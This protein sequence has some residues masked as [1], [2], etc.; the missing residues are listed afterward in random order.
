[1]SAAYSAWLRENLSAI[2]LAVVGVAAAVVG[3]AAAG[4]VFWYAGT[5]FAGWL[6]GR[7]ERRGVRR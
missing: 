3:V 6:I 4:V 5:R 7:S 2:A 1:M